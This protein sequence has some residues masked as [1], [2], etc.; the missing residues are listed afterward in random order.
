[1]VSKKVFIRSVVVIIVSLIVGFLGLVWF[2]YDIESQSAKV[3]LLKNTIARRVQ[4]V[5]LLSVLESEAEKANMYDEKLSRLLPGKDRLIDVRDF[6]E[7]LASQRGVT[8]QFAFQGEGG[9]TSSGGLSS[10]SFSLVMSGPLSGIM[11]FLQDIESKP[12][13]YLLA[14]DTFE[15]SRGDQ[16]QATFKGRLFYKDVE[17][18]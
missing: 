13:A 4:L 7:S 17:N 10:I 11:G 6:L 1:M 16:Y 5:P 8:L 3:Q 9:P 2:R 15:L 18:Q 14:L 12:R